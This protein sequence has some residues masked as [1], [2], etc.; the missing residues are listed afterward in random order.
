MSTYALESCLYF[1]SND[2]RSQSC[3]IPLVY[4]RSEGEWVGPRL[5]SWYLSYS[6]STIH[7][8]TDSLRERCSR[9]R[10]TGCPDCAISEMLPISC[11]QD[12]HTPTP[13][14]SVRLIDRPFQLGFSVHGCRISSPGSKYSGWRNTTRCCLNSW[15]VDSSY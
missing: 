3:S 4:V 7:G 15:I 14:V 11:R 6:Q 1:V 8:R 2:T 10:T 5:T 13:A 9:Q 12:L